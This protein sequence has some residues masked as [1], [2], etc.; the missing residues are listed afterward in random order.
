MM[1]RAL[2]GAPVAAVLSEE[3]AL[4]E[5]FKPGAPLCVAI[6]PL[7]GSANLENNI[8]VG[9]I[10]SIRPR[11]NDVLS[12][13]FEPGTAQCA[14]G[15]IVYGPQTTL[16][17]ALNTVCRHLHSRPARARLRADRAR[18]EDRAR[19]AGIRHQRLQSPALAWAGPRLYRRM[20]CRHQRQ[21]RARIS[22]CAGSVRWWRSRFASWCAAA[23]FSIRP[24]RVPAIA[25]DGF[26]CCTK[27]IRWRW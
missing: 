3:A 17:L 4:P 20:P 23:C 18:R 14:A 10:F 22:I 7:D 9:T 21:R 15:F 11:G 24:M 16:V 6:D 25:R 2:R 19:H 13:F 26:A 27:R 5:T 12:T 1:R 8:S